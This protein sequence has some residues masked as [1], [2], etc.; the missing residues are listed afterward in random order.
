MLPKPPADATYG[1]DLEK[2]LTVSAPQ[3]PPDF[4]DF[5]QKTYAAA[6][7]VP[8]NIAKRQ[9]ESGDPQIH[10]FEIEF[11]ALGTDSLAPQRIGGWLTVPADG[12]FVGT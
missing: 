8:L 3:G 2:L 5:W 4:A 12:K 10:L 7:Q 9:I 1:Y 11:D 6:R